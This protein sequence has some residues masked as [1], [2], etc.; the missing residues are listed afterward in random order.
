MMA[1][2]LPDYDR[3]PAV[4]TLMGFYFANFANWNMLHFGKLWTLFEASYPKGE[5]LPPIVDPR[6]FSQGNL[7]FSQMPFRAMFTNASNTELVQI[8]A[9]AF[10]R[11]WRKTLE[12][13]GYTH[14]AHLRP[15]FESDWKM[16]C[17]FLASNR[18]AAP[19]VFQSEVTYVNHL[20][21]G[22]D[23]DSYNDLAKLFKPFAPRTGVADYGREYSYLPEAATVALNIG[24]N[25]S[26]AGVSLQISCHSAVRK[27]DGTEVI[28]LTVTAKSDLLDSETN[29]MWKKL[30]Q[31]HDAVILGFDDV[32]TDFAHQMWGK[33]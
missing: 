2:N 17:E 23:W 29:A 19:Q 20:V 1:A 8:Q 32:T 21:R 18:L 25:L 28:Q 26:E 11:N 7:E 16:F 10:L 24:Y 3:P 31:C 27:P 22:T 14:Y 4:E 33:R 15:K 6:M 9:S 5:V 30:D 13:Q 12:N